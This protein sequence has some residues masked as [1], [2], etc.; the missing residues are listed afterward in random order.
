MASF[1]ISQKHTAYDRSASSALSGWR[2]DTADAFGN[3]SRRVKTHT[4]TVHDN[5]NDLSVKL[6]NLSSS[7]ARAEIEEAAKPLSIK[8]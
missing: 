7:I 8:K 4:Q 5:Y 2:G 6:Q 3:S 1:N